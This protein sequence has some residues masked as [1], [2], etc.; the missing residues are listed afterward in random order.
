MMADTQILSEQVQTTQ[1]DITI[2]KKEVMDLTTV[3]HEVKT[4]IVGSTLGKDGGLVSR[5]IAL[6]ED[7]E[8][9]RKE[10]QEKDVNDAKA[11]L[12][13]KIIWGMGGLILSIIANASINH[14]FK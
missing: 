6:E 3:L 12:Y 14:F 4:A 8:L 10:L 2:I 9:I 13:L 5:I 11:N 1:K 7:V